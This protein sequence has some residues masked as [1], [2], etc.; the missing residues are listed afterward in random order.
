VLEANP[1]RSRIRIPMRCFRCRSSRQLPRSITYDPAKWWTITFEF[2]REASRCLRSKAIQAQCLGQTRTY[3]ISHGFS[4]CG[5][6]CTV[7]A[8]DLATGAKLWAT[9]L[10]AVGTPQHSA[11]LN[12]VTM[13]D[14][15]HLAAI[16]RRACFVHHRP[17]VV[18]RLCRS[19]RLQDWNNT[20]SQGLSTGFCSDQIV[21]S[22]R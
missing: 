17:R 19:S 14:R 15:K 21:G 3:C 10:S 9:K 13:A 11:Y 12:Q 16:R 5:S 4:Q 1:S 2:V 18:W 8:R 6:G 22:A 20:R 7:V